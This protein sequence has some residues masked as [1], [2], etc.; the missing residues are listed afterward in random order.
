MP[1][2]QGDL[3][4]KLLLSQPELYN[5]QVDIPKHA[6]RAFFSILWDKGNHDLAKKVQLTI[7]QGQHQEAGFIEIKNKSSQKDDESVKLVT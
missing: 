6:I 4:L 2:N 3:H 7:L 1:E 5:I